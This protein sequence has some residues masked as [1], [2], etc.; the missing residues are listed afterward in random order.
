MSTKLTSQE[1]LQ[2]INTAKDLIKP[3]AEEYSSTEGILEN[4]S[5]LRN[6]VNGMKRSDAD[7]SDERDD[8]LGAC[9]VPGCTCGGF[10]F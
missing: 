5:D 8:S 6:E 3:L 9:G 1:K 7:D 10:L 4:L 2:R